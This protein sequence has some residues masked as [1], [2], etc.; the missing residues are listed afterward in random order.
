MLSGNPSLSLF[1]PLLI[2]ILVDIY[3]VFQDIVMSSLLFCLL[4]LNIVSF[5]KIEV[6][7]G[8]LHEIKWK[9]GNKGFHL[10]QTIKRQIL[11]KHLPYI[12]HCV[13]T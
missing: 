11:T 3:A 9:P 8:A 4:F 6:W 7:R 1:F 5:F 2:E 10:C 13:T 12:K